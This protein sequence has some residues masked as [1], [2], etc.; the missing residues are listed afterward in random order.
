MPIPR[1]STSN[2]VLLV[3]DIQEAF[4]GHVH[5]YERISINAAI[6]AE[7]SGLLGVP[8]IVTEHYPGGLGRTLE[9]VRQGLPSGTPVFEKT[10]FS[11]AVPET[12]QAI[13]RLGRPNVL[14]CGIEAHVCVLQTALDLLAAGFQTFHLTDAIGAG[15]PFQVAPAFR[16]ME[17]AGS[18]PSG[19]LSTIYEWLGDARNPAFKAALTLAKRI[20]PEAANHDPA[21]SRLPLP[22]PSPGRGS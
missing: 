16:R 2:C 20:R 8:V 15:Q 4:V 7:A 21:I 19:V 10:R 18:I 9:L 11:A 14:L 3:I 17:R 6:A 13:Q 12:L 22:V 1:L 5:D